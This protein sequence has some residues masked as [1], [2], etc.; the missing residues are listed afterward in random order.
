MFRL[1]RPIEKDEFFVV[2]GDCSQGGKDA[3]FTQFM[4]KTRRD[5]PLVFEMQGVAAEATPHIREALNWI[6]S[7]TGVKPTVGLERNN[8]GASEMHV[9]HT[10]NDGNY[11]IYHPKDETGA[12]NEDKLGWDTT[13]GINGTGT[14]PTMLGDW[15]IAYENH[16]ITIYDKKTQDQHKTFIVS[17][18]GKPQAA[19]NTHDDGVMS[20]AGAYQLYQ[21]ES[22]P[23]KLV[24]RRPKPK[25]S[26]YH[27]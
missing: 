1:F 21:T 18:N 5:I 20:A 25:R 9:L 23:V 22:A 24:A 12:E 16:I 7:K 14:R 8:G 4:S 19:S 11:R 10:T 3:N 27:I 15:L 13:G 2:F 26:H 6:Y 17:K